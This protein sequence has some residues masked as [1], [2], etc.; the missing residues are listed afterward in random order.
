MECITLG[1]ISGMAEYMGTL[2][3]SGEL[4]ME[5]FAVGIISG[6]VASVG[7]ILGFSIGKKCCT[8][9]S[10]VDSLYAKIFNNEARL[11]DQIFKHEINRRP[12]IETVVADSAKQGENQ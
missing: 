12:P 2:E 11:Y 10:D 6:M 4:I 8:M 7:T 5:L 3:F 1:I 9:R